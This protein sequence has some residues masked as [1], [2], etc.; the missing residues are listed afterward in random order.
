GNE[1]V[2]DGALSLDIHIPEIK[3]FKEYFLNKT[4]AKDTTK[5]FNL[6]W[7]DVFD[8]SLSTTSLRGYTKSCKG[9]E[10]L[11]VGK[12]YY[13]NTPVHTVIEAVFHIAT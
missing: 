4:I 1:D 6:F 3:Q 9:T 10:R 13:P 11:T 5:Y 7:E 8:C 12:G 2:I